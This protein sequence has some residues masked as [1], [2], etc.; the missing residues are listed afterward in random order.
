MLCC[1][2]AVKNRIAQSVEKMSKVGGSLRL[3]LETKH[4]CCR[5][6]V[7]QCCGATIKLRYPKSMAFSPNALADCERLLSVV[8]MLNPSEEAMAK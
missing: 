8:T 6:A 1:R 4:L 7:M 5:A 3:R 2:A